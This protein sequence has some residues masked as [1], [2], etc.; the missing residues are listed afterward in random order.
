MRLARV[1]ATEIIFSA[2]MHAE[3]R[4]SEW[5]QALQMLSEV[6]TAGAELGVISLNTAISACD[7]AGQWKAALHV[8]S[9]AHPNEISFNAAIAACNFLRSGL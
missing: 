7:E 1:L 2:E 6:S 3:G 8:L 9:Q 5:L 4:A